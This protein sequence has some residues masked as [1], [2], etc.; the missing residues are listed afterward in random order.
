M[1]SRGDV[2]SP[3]CRTDSQPVKALS[4]QQRLRGV[5]GGRTE[6]SQ[7]VCS[8]EAQGS[9]PLIGRSV[10]IRKLKEAGLRAEWGVD[11]NL[12]GRG[13]CVMSRHISLQQRKKL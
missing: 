9:A 7:P 8:C 4:E 2:S 6:R 10:T 1:Q 12:G 5:D 11:Q 3:G 13:V